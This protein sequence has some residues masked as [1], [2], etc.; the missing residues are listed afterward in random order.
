MIIDSNVIFGAE[1]ED[2]TDLSIDRI[3]GLM[4]EKKID[5]A[6]ITNN[7]C[8]FYDFI[9]GNDKTA[10]IA[11]KYPDKF[12]GMAS[13]NLSQLLNIKSEVIRSIS[14][15]GLA[16]IRFFNTD[17]NFTSGWGGGIDSLTAYMVFDL[18]NGMGV[19]VFIEGGY[20]FKTIGALAEK[21]P[22]IP[23]IASGTGYGNMG[24]AILAAKD[25]NNLFLE[26]STLDS[27]DGI[28][29]LVE[30]LGA[31]RI[32]FGTGMPYN[33]PSCEILMVKTSSVSEADR[34]KIFSGNIQKILDGR[35]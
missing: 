4:D 1:I 10:E 13:F 19:P 30:N 28:D 15:L 14:E 35:K 2:D 21:Y 29:I 22:G 5:K 25:K 24:E 27:M 17:S 7:Q 11:A 23:M 34:Q 18:I 31:D 32:I 16:G 20:P 33:S 6:L 9:E 12:Y 26:I 8:K 3:L